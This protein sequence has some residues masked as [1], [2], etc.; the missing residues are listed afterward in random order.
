MRKKHK[1]PPKRAP[2]ESWVEKQVDSGMSPESV[3]ELWEGATSAWRWKIQKKANN[4]AAVLIAPAGEIGCPI[5]APPQRWVEERE[6]EGMT[7]DDIYHAWASLTYSQRS[8]Q[9]RLPVLRNNTMVAALQRIAEGEAT[10]RTVLFVQ[11][12]GLRHHDTAE[13]A[14]AAKRENDREA[15]QRS[16]ADRL[17]FALANKL[18]CVEPGCVL[19]STGESSFLMLLQHDHRD[20]E[21][22][23]DQVTVLSGV[24]RVLEV[25]KT[26]CKCLWHHF[27]HTRQQRKSAPVCERKGAMQMLS[28]RKE[29]VGCQHPLHGSMIYSSLVPSA[30]DDPLMYG[31][32]DVSHVIRGKT[33]RQP[34]DR[35]LLADLDSGTAVVQCK[36]CH[37]LYTVCENAKLFFSATSQHHFAVLLRSVPSFVQHFEQ[38]TAGFDWDSYREE[39]RIVKRKAKS[40]EHSPTLFENVYGNNPKRFRIFWNAPTHSLKSAVAQITS[41]FFTIVDDDSA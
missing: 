15:S 39:Q 34:G 29:E 6:A 38:T 37:W 30:T 19:S 26:D 11:K 8:D 1:M 40:V 7:P 41:A 13:K 12:G 23:I 14:Q 20:E 24:A 16:S 18:G 10:M 21:E 22:K 17:S 25:A 9:R 32:L 3:K 36:F 28:R 35:Q 27:V 4:T 5:R 2:P 33:S 31:F